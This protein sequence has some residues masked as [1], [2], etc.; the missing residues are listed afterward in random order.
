MDLVTNIPGHAEVGVL[1]NA[2]RN[3]AGNILISNDVGEAGGEAGRGLN[4]RIGCHPAIV[5]HLKPED[6]PQGI[7]IDMPLEPA[8]VRVQLSHVL[9][10]DKDEGLLRVQTDSYDVLDVLVGKSREL[11]KV[12]AL[13]VEIFL[14]VG[15]LD[16]EGNVERLLQVLTEDE[17]QHVPKMKS[18]G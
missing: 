17:R 5:A 2:A 8:D 15:H 10:V 7:E 4:G 11:L 18:L 9:R 6:R 1:V 14:I 16:H 12:A 3:K 13:L